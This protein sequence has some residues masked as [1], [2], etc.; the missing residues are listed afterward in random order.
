MVLNLQ[1]AKAITK[2]FHMYFEFELNIISVFDAF[3][4]LMSNET[5]F[6][7]NDRAKLFRRAENQPLNTREM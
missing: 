3:V 5:L 6:K 2:K 1:I 7:S 4:P